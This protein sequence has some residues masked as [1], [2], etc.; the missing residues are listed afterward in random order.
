MVVLGKV[1]KILQEILQ[2]YLLFAWESLNLPD[3]EL[4][5]QYTVGIGVCNAWE[6]LEQQ[7]V[8]AVLMSDAKR[9]N[10]V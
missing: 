4:I 5:Q 9:I 7:A 1:R 3:H 2:S 8:C 6:I 10:R